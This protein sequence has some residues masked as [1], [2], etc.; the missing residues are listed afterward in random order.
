MANLVTTSAPLAIE[1]RDL[2]FAYA[3]A[4]PMLAIKEFVLGRGEHVFLHGPSGSGKTTLLGLLAGILQP[5]SGRISILGQDIAT[6][7]PALRDQLR[8]AHMGYIFQMFNLI[9]YLNVRQNITLP[10]SLSQ[11]RAARA[12]AP[13][14]ETLNSLAEALHLQDLLDQKVTEL[15]VGQQQRVAAARALIGAPE[16]IIADEPTSALDSDRRAAFLST[17]FKVAERSQSSI[18]FVSHDHGLKS[19][20]QRSLSL[21]EIN[22]AASLA[23]TETEL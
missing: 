17:M 22:S 6:M 18:L 4:R 5:R 23:P 14:A 9:P 19:L 2:Q 12:M 16:I 1:L 7:R 8:G 3:G 10:L 11:R 21:R 15:S 13:Q 20:F